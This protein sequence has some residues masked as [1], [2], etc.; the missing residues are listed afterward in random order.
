MQGV[1]LNETNDVWF[2]TCIV[3]R[4]SECRGLGSLLKVMR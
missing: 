4:L 2:G 1:F 3:A